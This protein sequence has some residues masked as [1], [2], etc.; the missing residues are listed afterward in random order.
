MLGGCGESGKTDEIPG[1]NKY[2]H[3]GR[4]TESS[5]RNTGVF[6]EAPYVT[7][8]IRLGLESTSCFHQKGNGLQLIEPNITDKRAEQCT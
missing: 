7:W 2:A 6:P 4:P 3:K 1:T 8:R 5:A